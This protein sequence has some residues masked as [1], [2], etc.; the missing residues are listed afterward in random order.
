MFNFAHYPR[1][2][3]SE[4]IGK[5]IKH[6][7]KFHNISQEQLANNSNV[8][9]R[10]FSDIETGKRNPSINILDQ[11]AKCFDMSVGQF[12][13]YAEKFDNFPVD[14]ESLKTYL[15]ELGFNEAILFESP[16]FLD[17]IIGVSDDGRVV[18]DFSLMVLSLVHNDAM[19]YEEAIEFIEYNTVR[20]LPYMGEH[21]PII[22]R[23]IEL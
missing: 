16:E 19:T 10:Y 7:R 21:A 20:A 3:L 11:I 8:D 18:Y 1:M 9:R 5:A 17:A 6:L 14:I 12:L 2:N 4:K 23:E 13:T 22:V 15:C